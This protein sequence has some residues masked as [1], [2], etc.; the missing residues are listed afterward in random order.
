MRTK[1]R[2]AVALLVLLACG[3]VGAAV[4]SGDSEATPPPVHRCDGLDPSVCLYPWPNNYFTTHDSSTDTG[5]R[6]N[7]QPGTTPANVRGVHIDPSEWNLSDGFSPGDPI[8]TKVPGLDTQQALANTGAPT[9]NNLER[10]FAPGQAIVVIDAHT[11]KRQLIWAEVDANASTAANAALEIHPAVNFLEGHRYIVALR[12]LRDSDNKPIEAQAEFR[13]LRDHRP[14]KDPAIEERRAHYRGI[15][16]RLSKAGIK[17]KSLYLAWDFTV[18]SERNLTER[19]LYIRDDAFAQLGDANLADMKVEGGVPPYTI[20]SV[21]NFA[22]CGED[23][24]QAGES[25]QLIRRVQGSVTVPCYLNRVG[26]PP[27]SRF[28]HEPP[29][30][31][32]PTRLPGNTMQA[33]FICNIP[34]AA[35]GNGTVVPGRP[36]LLGHGLFGSASE[37]NSGSRVALAA[38]HNFVMCATDWIGMASA[39]VPTAIA[40]LQ[41]LSNFATTPD[42]LQQSYLNFMYLGRLLDNPAGFNADP[43]FQLPS[44]GGMK[45]VIDTQR[46]YYDGGSQ[47][48]IAG[49]AL[50]AL[51]PDWNR[52]A[53]GVPGMNYSVLLPRSVDFDKFAVFMN[54]SYTNQLERP[55]IFSMLQVL[56]DRGDADG[57][58]QHMTDDP[59]PNT[60]PHR[61]LLHEAFGDHQ[62]ANAATEVEARTIGAFLRE[63]ALDPG[64]STADQPFFGI[65][66]IESFPFQGSVLEVWDVG[67][68]R[69][70]NGVVKGTPP[71]PIT[72]TP[73]RL[74][75]DPHGPDASEEP[76]ARTQ[77][78]EFLQPDALSQIIDVCGPHPCY[79]DGWTGP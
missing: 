19:A 32:L 37:V 46:L 57:Y 16:H 79:L 65:P 4:A 21:T 9:L 12:N 40:G 63:P 34:R 75:V 17:R 71:P 60:P 8:V 13:A 7:I 64:R 69:T 28:I 18:A 76:T 59:L 38:E 53:L 6:L 14:T 33:N 15:F 27:G 68:L 54:A 62:V 47:G 2:I 41:D 39:D 52:A 1:F 3:L 66:R 36:T 70:E 48:G 78:S 5:R 31:P 58:A 50:T 35:A 49:G 56:W 24:C 72:N 77:I 23:G 25:D 20:S 11:L 73:N 44:D 51:A 42:R 10:S 67:P 45:G 30:N 43:A 22:P 26:C 74:G 55:L 61:V 29:S